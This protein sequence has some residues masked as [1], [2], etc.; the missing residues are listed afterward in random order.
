M[1]RLHELITLPK[2]PYTCGK[3]APMLA[4]L[5]PK[6]GNY[7]CQKSGYLANFLPHVRD[8]K[9]GR[10]I[11]VWKKIIALKPLIELSLKQSR[12]KLLR[13]KISKMNSFLL[14]V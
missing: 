11:N 7:F 1:A 12:K 4:N 14:L 5:H 6:T 8:P 13:I 9:G 2:A 10:E 3:K